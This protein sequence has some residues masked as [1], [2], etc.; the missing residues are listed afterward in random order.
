MF[1]DALLPG[2][3]IQAGGAAAALA[4]VASVATSETAGLST[5]IPVAGA[6]TVSTTESGSISTG[7]P[8]QGAASVSVNESGTLVSGI[9]IG[10]SASVAEGM[11]GNLSTGIPLSGS[12]GVGSSAA[13]QFANPVAGSGTV[14]VSQVGD[15]STGIDLAGQG[16][17]VTS[18]LARKTYRSSQVILSVQKKGSDNLYWPDFPQGNR[19]ASLQGSGSIGSTAVASMST[20][21]RL[22]VAAAIALSGTAALSNAGVVNPLG[23]SLGGISPYSP[24]QP[25]LNILKMAGIAPA[26]W[27]TGSSSTFDTQEEGYI[28]LDSNGYP[29]SMTASPTPAGGQQFTKVFV[30]INYQLGTPTGAS[31]PFR[32]GTYRIKADGKGQIVMGLDASGTFNFPGG[33][34]N[35]FTFNVSSPNNGIALEIH[36]TDPDSTGDYLRNLSV[37]NTSYTSSFDAGAIYDPSYLSIVSNF[38]TLRFMDYSA[39]ANE[40]ANVSLTTTPSSGSTS[41]T[42]TSAWTNSSGVYSCMFSSG[43]TRLVTFTVGSTGVT[44]TTGLTQAGG[45][46]ALYYSQKRG[47]DWAHRPTLNT[48]FWSL[49]DGVPLEAQVALCN[50]VAADMWGNL[51]SHYTDS[52]MANYF[53]FIRD[54][55]AIG[56]KFVPEYSNEVWNGFQTQGQWCQ[57]RGTFLWGAGSG[58]PF[59]IRLCYYGRR[60]AEMADIC[61]TSFGNPGFDNRVEVSLGAQ[62]A[63][64]YTATEAA[65]SPIWVTQNGATA[66]YLRTSASGQKTIKGWHMA[67]YFGGWS[68]GQTADQTDLN[69]M[70]ACATPLDDFFATLTSQTGTV[71]NGSHNYSSSVPVGGWLTQ[72][73]GWMDAYVSAKASYGNPRLRGYES[74]QSFYGA[75]H[76]GD[77]TAVTTMFLNANRDARMGTVYKNYYARWKSSGADGL[78]NVF[79]EISSYNQYGEWGA[80][81]SLMQTLSPLTSAPAKWQATVNYVAGH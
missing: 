64:T 35:S 15:L 48:A 41:A 16:Q 68:T 25:F 13:A 67:P 3:Q 28:Q 20:G 18:I 43:E 8:L 58:T 77:G 40:L 78:I 81:E 21:V 75:P 1:F 33:T 71:G 70:A 6:A 54:N 37:V 63:N 44:W 38:S 23:L 7:V 5:G 12:A 52:D 60:V 42:L 55:L 80:L 59:D 62:A 31:V 79:V 49:A 4:G 65:S 72:A 76:Y 9:P 17:I 39:I 2:A 27:I 57:L 53:N 30:L 69:F 74:G 10:G 61:A 56:R 73:Y 46:N 34:G 22:A 45:G 14:G 50:T 36:T 32:A 24:N 11:V 26:G 47:Y 19:P 51:P 29:T 66:P